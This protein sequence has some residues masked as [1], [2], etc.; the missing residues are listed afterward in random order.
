MTVFLSDLGTDWACYRVNKIPLA[1]C[2]NCKALWMWWS[3]PGRAERHV[4]CALCPVLGKASYKTLCWCKPAPVLN[5]SLCSEASSQ[6]KILC[7]D[8]HSKTAPLPAAHHTRTITSSSYILSLRTSQCAFRD[9]L[10]RLCLPESGLIADRIWFS[11]FGFDK[12]YLLTLERSY[13]T[14]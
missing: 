6:Y 9:W 10:F 1:S 8:R 11:I 5:R 14:L 7:I 3:R 12:A 2:D 4:A 13:A